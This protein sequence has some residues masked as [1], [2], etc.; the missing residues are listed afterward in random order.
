M[1]HTTAESGKVE[2][3][4]TPLAP[5]LKLAEEKKKAVNA[6]APLPDL[7]KIIVA[8]VSDE[9]VAAIEAEGQQRKEWAESAGVKLA[10]VEAQIDRLRGNSGLAFS[11]KGKAMLKDL[12]TAKAQILGVGD[13]VIQARVKFS[14]LL[15][16]IRSTDRTDRGSAQAV[17]GMLYRLESE[18]RFRT[19][20]P[21]EIKA[22]PKDEKGKKKFPS[23]TVFFPD[24]VLFSCR[25]ETGEDASA[26]QRAI[27]AETRKMVS[28]YKD[29]LTERLKKEELA[30]H[31]LAGFNKGE[32]G[33]YYMYVP[34]REDPKTHRRFR[35]GN[36]VVELYDRNAQNERMSAKLGIFEMVDICDATGSCATLATGKGRKS[37]PWFWIRRGEVVTQKRDDGKR[38]QM[39]QEDFSRSV[40]ILRTIQNAL[41][42]WK[43]EKKLE[44]KPKT[45]KKA[46][47]KA[48]TVK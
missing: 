10:E 20:T 22:L 17:A 2:E 8:E 48:K 39:P 5:K 29:G 16:D 26:G 36:M 9:A 35:D 38:K 28:E 43:S 40:R 7:T 4:R 25:G 1:E 42:H 12:E 30:S 34:P 27:E 14:R 37:I 32:F 18:G 13:E 3:L 41:D 6:T 19:A 21:A 11:E 23:G 44:S 47:P 45:A 46:K 33:R 15:E 24:R 31:D